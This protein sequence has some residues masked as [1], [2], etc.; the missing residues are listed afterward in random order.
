MNDDKFLWFMKSEHFY[1]ILNL[2]TKDIKFVVVG[3][4]TVGKSCLLNVYATGQFPI[5]YVPTV[6]ENLRKKTTYKNT[7]VNAHLWD[8]AGQEQLE[9]MRLLS[10]PKTDVFLL[11]FSVVEPH[12]FENITTLWIKEINDFLK[13]NPE[14]KKPA[15]VLVGTKSDLRGDSNV[16]NQ[17]AQQNMKPITQEQ[18][19]EK[20]SQLLA[21]D[22]IETS[23][24]K[25]EN[26]TAL[27]EA[28]IEYVLFPPEKGCCN[29]M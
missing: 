29:V 6:F 18:G 2:M 4:G 5:D 16:L 7:D 13:N 22:Y 26:V 1:S 21:I 28:A 17:L 23:A 19:K 10:Y 12:S 25:N 9:A 27:F 15:F 3:D 24:L 20:A 14:E 11:C 8:T